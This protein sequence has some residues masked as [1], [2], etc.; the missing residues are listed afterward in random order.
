MKGFVYSVRSK[1]RPDLIY[2]GST[3]RTLSQRMATHRSDAKK[4]KKCTSSQIILLGDAYIELE[5]TV[6]YTDKQELR[7]VEYLYIR[8]EECVNRLGKGTSNA[9]LEKQKKAARVRSQIPEVKARARAYYEAHK[10]KCLEHSRKQRE[11]R[12][13]AE[14]SKYCKELRVKNIAKAVAAALNGV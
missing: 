5:E 9:S 10:E 4:E 8:N 3:K 7:A 6:E 12:D 11:G 1:S 2:Y 14:W 13:P